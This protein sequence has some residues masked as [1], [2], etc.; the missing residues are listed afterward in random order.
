MRNQVFNI[1]RVVVGISV[2]QHFVG[3]VSLLQSSSDSGRH[4]SVSN[5]GLSIVIVSLFQNAK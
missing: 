4:R 2:S 3:N 1:Q 5:I